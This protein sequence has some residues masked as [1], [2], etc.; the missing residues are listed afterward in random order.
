MPLHELTRHLVG[1]HGKVMRKPRGK[2]E[3]ESKKK[4]RALGEDSVHAQG[5]SGEAESSKRM[6]M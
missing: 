2:Q 3:R 5:E 4:A 6:R 1:V